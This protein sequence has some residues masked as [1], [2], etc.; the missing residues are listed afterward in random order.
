[1]VIFST[2]SKGLQTA[3]DKLGTYCKEWG[4]TVNNAKTKVMVVSHSNRSNK[5]LLVLTYHQQELEWVRGF[6]YLGVFVDD[7]GRMQTSQAPIFQKA[8]RAQFKLTS[9]GKSLSFDTKMWL[10]QIMVD[11]ILLHGCEIWAVEGRPQVLQQQELYSTYNKGGTKPLAIE[12]I[13][14]RYTRIQMGLPRSAPIL[15]IRGDSGIMPLYIEA[16]A[17]TLQYHQL[18]TKVEPHSLLGAAMKIQEQMMTRNQ[19]CWLSNVPG[20]RNQLFKDT[21]YQPDKPDIIDKMQGEYKQEWYKHLWKCNNRGR[22]GTK[23]KWY[24]KMKTSM[25]KEQYLE[26]PMSEIQRSMARFRIGGHCLPVEVGR[27]ENT[28]C[29]NRLCKQCD[30]KVV[31]NE[32]HIFLCPANDYMKPRNFLLPKNKNNTPLY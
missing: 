19:V 6:T 16:L 3:M 1:M 29:K 9:L 8:T 27:W 18:L 30:K 15:A 17:R 26:G 4:L 11:P 13:K 21:L 10:Q 12:H 7:Q 14:R 2:S 23:L 5:T 32:P 31:G 28:R 24:R 22:M 25:G 20:V